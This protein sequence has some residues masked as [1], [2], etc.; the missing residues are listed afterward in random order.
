MNHPPLTLEEE[1][2]LRSHSADVWDATWAHAQGIDTKKAFIEG[3][4][5]G[6]ACGVLAV[7]ATHK[8]YLEKASSRPWLV[9]LLLVALAV[10]IIIG[11]A[12]P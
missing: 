11:R 7:R 12:L 3:H 1:L 6:M 4:Y 10:G 9:L 8:L 5:I 2:S